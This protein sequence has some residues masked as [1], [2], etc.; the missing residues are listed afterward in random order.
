VIGASPKVPTTHPALDRLGPWRRARS[1]ESGSRHGARG[2]RT[3]ELRPAVFV[4]KD[5]TLIEN[6]PYN[7]DPARLRFM[8]GATDA[9]RRLAQ[10]GFA[11]VMVTNQSGLARG[12]FSA[13]QWDTLLG[14][15]LERLRREAGV[16]LLDVMVCPHAPG[17]DGLPLCTCRKPSPGMLLHA[18]RL[19]RLDL[20]RSWMIGDTLDDIEAGRRAGCRTVLFHSGGETLWQRSA[21]RTPLAELDDWREVARLLTAT[22]DALHAAARGG[23][24]ALRSA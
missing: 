2:A 21:L 7:A 18:A 5:G 24:H 15:L 17:S 16:A 19:H 10:R 11:L 4:D 22:G 3:A 6:V 9:L 14:V 12:H 1:R 20:A 23:G 8:P 13:E